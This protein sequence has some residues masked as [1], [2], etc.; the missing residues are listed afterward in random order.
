MTQKYP[1]NLYFFFSIDLRRRESDEEGWRRM[2]GWFFVVDVV[3][4]SGQLTWRLSGNEFVNDQ[5]R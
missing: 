4:I 5:K 3:A 2:S 1:R